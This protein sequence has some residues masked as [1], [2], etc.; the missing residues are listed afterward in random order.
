MRHGSLTF[1]PAVLASYNPDR[2]SPLYSPLINPNG[3]KHLPPTYF[4]IC[5]IDPLRDE[6]LIYEREL[7]EECG[8]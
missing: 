2:T 8:V 6:G 5:G 7:R 3:H 4:Q 1:V